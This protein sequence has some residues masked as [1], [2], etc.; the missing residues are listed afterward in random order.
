M[1]KEALAIL[2]ELGYRIGRSAVIAELAYTFARDKS[3]RAA[4]LLG[5]AGGLCEDVGA[6]FIASERPRNARYV[7][8]A[9]CFGQ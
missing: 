9:R 6:P 2:L 7:A 3:P 1:L 4:R 8:T 5:A